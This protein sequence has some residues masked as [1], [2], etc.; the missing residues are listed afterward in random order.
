VLAP[1]EPRSTIPE[2]AEGADWTTETMRLYRRYE[3]E[4]VDAYEL[5]PW[6]AQV[7]RDAR[8]RERVLLQE[9]I[10]A[11]QPSLVAIDSL[12]AD[13][14]IALLIYPRLGV[15]RTVFEQFASRVR[16]ADVARHPLGAAPFVF[17]VFHPEAVPDL[18][19]AERLIPFLRRTPDPTIQLLRSSVLER[20]RGTVSHG[21]QFVDPR[22]LDSLQPQAPSLRERIA[23]TNL[24]TTLRIGVE[25]L[26]RRLDDIAEDRAATHRALQNAWGSVDGAGP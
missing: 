12:G 11:P 19:D 13:V 14:D 8:V 6:A 22:F 5:C 24:A 25:T 9:D 15:G 20:I 21:T 4:I 16:D 3:R 18:D 23:R 7:R 2:S 10:L 1:E 17:A 26:A